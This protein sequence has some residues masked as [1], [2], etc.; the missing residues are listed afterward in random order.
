MLLYCLLEELIA[1]MSIALS[2][3]PENGTGFSVPSFNLENVEL[4]LRPDFQ[5]YFTIFHL[6]DEGLPI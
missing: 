5:I 6:T 2:H 1:N 3:I 4:Q